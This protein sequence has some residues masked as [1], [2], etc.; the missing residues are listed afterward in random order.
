[1]VDVF[2]PGATEVIVHD[3]REMRVEPTL[4]GFQDAKD[5]NLWHFEST[6]LYPGLPH[7]YRVR[8]TFRNPDGTETQDVRYLRLIMGRVVELRF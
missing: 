6:P 3:I 4:E 8:A 5:P 7:I 2:V 1:M